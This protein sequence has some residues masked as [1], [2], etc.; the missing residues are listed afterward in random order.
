[1]SR[2]RSI[3]VHF[4]FYI[5]EILGGLR[6]GLANYWGGLSPPSPPPPFGAATAHKVVTVCKP[7]DF[8]NKIRTLLTSKTTSSVVNCLHCY[9]GSPVKIMD[10]TSGKKL[11]FYITIIDTQPLFKPVQSRIYPL[12]SKGVCDADPA[13]NRIWVLVVCM[14]DHGLRE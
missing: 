13:E 3:P 7:R 6:G 10:G 14:F 8:T 9:L 5:D 11:W 4:S 12:A 2:S 1:M